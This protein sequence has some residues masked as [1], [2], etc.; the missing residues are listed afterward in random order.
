MR[1]ATSD[2]FDVIDVSG[3]V[4]FYQQVP[5]E[6]VKLSKIGKAAKTSV[7]MLRFSGGLNIID[8]WLRFNKYYLID[9]LFAETIK[10][11][12]TDKAKIFYGLIAALGAGINETFLTDDITT[13]NK[14]CAKI[15]ED[16]EA[17][18]YDVDETTQFIIVCNPSLKARISKALASTWATQGINNQVVF[19]FTA[20][21]MT[22]KI[23]STSY[24]VCVPNIKAQRGEWED[25]TERPAQR[26]ERILGAAHIWTGAYNGIIA[27]AKQFRR[28]ALS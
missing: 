4:T 16:L 27:E 11:W 5:G 19:N 7:G 23:A 8:D 24:Y 9:R 12:F 10:R 17:A 25:L 28:C 26:D 18:G 13:I 1:Q 21:V 6:E 20:I 22:T 3:G 14:A 15:L 2:S